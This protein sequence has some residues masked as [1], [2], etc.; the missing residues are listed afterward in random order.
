MGINEVL[1]LI[2][3]AAGFISPETFEVPSLV[4]GTNSIMIFQEVESKEL[5]ERQFL[6]KVLFLKAG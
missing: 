5:L 4:N 3:K 1:A 2:L 6:E